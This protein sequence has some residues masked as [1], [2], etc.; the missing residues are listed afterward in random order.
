[1]RKRLLFR[2]E[3]ALDGVDGVS[4]GADAHAGDVRHVA[5]RLADD[6]GCAMGG[7]FLWAALL[8]GGP[9]YVVTHDARPLSFLVAVAGVVVAAALG[10]LVGV[11]IATLRLLLLVRRLG[12]VAAPRRG[13]RHVHLH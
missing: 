6:C 13:F 3:A 8:L 9:A 12:S 11:G 1:M 4:G 7:I 5:A 2:V 10:K